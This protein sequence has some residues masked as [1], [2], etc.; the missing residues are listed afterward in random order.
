MK[1]LQNK[2]GSRV[3]H[4]LFCTVVGLL[5][6]AIPANAQTV[7][8][9][10]GRGFFADGVG[11]AAQF[12]KPAG[13]AM[14]AAGNIYVADKTN[15]R[16][17]KITSAGVV[18]TLAGNGYSGYADGAGIVAQFNLPI[19]IAVDGAGN[20]YVA[21]Q[22]NHRIRKITPS[23]LVSTLAGSSNSGYSDGT[24]TSA[25]F[26]SP[27]GIAVNGEGMIFLA[28]EGNHRIR[29]IT[30]GGLVSTLAGSGNAGYMDGAGMTAQFSSPSGIAV[31]WS[32]NVYV[33]DK[34]NNRIRK[35]TS[36]G[37]VSTFAGSG[38]Q[39]YGD[40]MG[41]SALFNLPNGVVVDWT[42]N[43]Y[44]ADQGNQCIRKIT[45]L[46]AVSTLAGNGSSGF[47]DGTGGMAQFSFPA[48]VAID[49]SGNVYVADL[50]ND[51]IRRITPTAVVSTLAGSNHIGYSDGSGAESQFFNPSGVAV[52]ADGNVYVA[53]GSNNRIRKINTM[54]IVST[55]AGK[56]NPGYADGVVSTASFNYPSGISLDM[57]GNIFVT[58][59]NR[60]RKINS[61]GVVSTFAG[62]G[63]F[64]YFDGTGA[65]AQFKSPKGVAVD[66]IGNVYVADKNN[67]R[68]R[69]INSSGTVSTLA[70]SWSRN[71]SVGGGYSD[72]TGTEAQFYYPEGVAV[73]GAGNVYVAD[74][75][76]NRIRKITPSGVV[77]TLAGNNDKGSADGAGSAALFNYPSGVTVDGA[78]NVYVADAGNN[79]I[80]R[81]TLSGVVSTIAGNG[82][83]G[84]YDGAGA[85]AQFNRPWGIAVDNV[86]NIYVADVG[87]N[88]I[89]K[90]TPAAPV[91]VK[92]TS[93]NITPALSLAIAPHPVQDEANLRFTL[94]ATSRVDVLL[95]DV[96]GRL[97]REEV[98]GV[99][100]EGTH[101]WL[102]GMN[103]FPHGTYTVIMRAGTEQST[104]FVQHIR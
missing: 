21:D 96:L 104:K 47:A 72:G 51:R 59:G 10:A 53:D 97:V 30:P 27:A 73:D 75:S 85:T 36:A 82:N 68:I 66:A 31:D 76:N 88:R 38:S 6:Q 24:G 93:S 57:M 84:Y 58:D 91:S 32:G 16:I 102:L 39:G 89:R 8:T 86:G 25:R 12:D 33:A 1:T 71:N 48:G 17:R 78:G 19:G 79:C 5:L 70:G 22:G 99:L 54:S 18:T 90:I 26:N 46:G 81:I 42:D 14:D 65:M 55:Y 52:D 74:A 64:G 9:L 87:N 62:S 35:I 94:S 50:F 23:G 49:G 3:F 95:F 29:K 103:A 13:V 45:P 63:D 60:I 40:G 28:D 80:R 20:V 98:L 7:S 15:N 34:T 92:F 37:L 2:I 67:N 100:P 77:T 83:S 4:A 44:V 43:V 56:G 61:N 101:E 11:A 69:R 41:A